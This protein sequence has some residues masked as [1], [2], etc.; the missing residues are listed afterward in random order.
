VEKRA[1][2]SLKEIAP[3]ETHKRTR[4]VSE[5]FPVWNSSNCGLFSLLI[6]PTLEA[7]F[8]LELCGG[9]PLALLQAVK[10]RVPH[11]PVAQAEACVV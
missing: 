4:K 7:H 1:S 6:A 5:T 3:A 11:T 9:S 10:A 8:S 2:G